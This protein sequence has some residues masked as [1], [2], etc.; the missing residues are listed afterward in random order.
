VEDRPLEIEEGTVMD[1]RD[2]PRPVVVGV[3]GSEQAVRAVRWGAAE[4]ARRHVPLRLV[5]AFAWSTPP[6][7]GHPDLRDRYRELLLERAEISLGAAVRLAEREAQGIEVDDQLLVGPPGAVLWSKARRAEL[8]VVGDRGR[9][10]LG[11][12]LAGSVAAELA[13]RACCPVVVVRG[14]ERDPDVA[15]RLPVVV[16]VDGA[17]SDPAI[18]F[19]VE[20]AVARHVPLVAVH[21]WSVPLIDPAAAPLLDLEAVEADARELLDTQLDAWAEKHP[22]LAVERVV[23]RDRSAR[24]LLARSAAAQLV[25]VGSRG[26]GPLA[27]LVLGSVGNALVHTADCPVAVV[28]AA[29]GGGHDAS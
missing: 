2:G 24:Q 5:S 9:T 17:A 13:A 21:T 29:A 23:V 4:A 18:S 19:A 27:G 8:V 28:R 6:E 11:G 20:A 16:G 1:R 3:D 10:R 7:V 26:R 25:V 14:P 22:D 12:L 15:A